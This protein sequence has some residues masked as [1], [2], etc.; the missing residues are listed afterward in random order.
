M[1]FVPVWRWKPAKLRTNY[2][3]GDSTYWHWLC[4]WTTSKIA[5]KRRVLHTDD[6]SIDN[7]MPKNYL[8]ETLR[9]PCGCEAS[10]VYPLPTYCPQHGSEIET[11]GK[12]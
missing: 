5:I 6:L 9:Y 7:P 8:H 11:E 10:G 12:P 4:F 1:T 2:G 3:M